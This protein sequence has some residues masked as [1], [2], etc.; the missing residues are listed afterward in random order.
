M[1]SLETHPVQTLSPAGRS[2]ILQTDGIPL[3]S[4]C[5]L[6]DYPNSPEVQ[7]SIVNHS[8]VST[9]RQPS[10]FLPVLIPVVVAFV[11][12][13][14]VGFKVASLLHPTTADIL[15][16]H[17]TP[18]PWPWLAALAQWLI[19]LWLLTGL[20]ATWAARVTLALLTLFLIIASYHWYTGAADCGCFGAVA[21]HPRWTVLLDG[22][23]LVGIGLTTA[24]SRRAF[25]SDSYPVSNLKSPRIFLAL[26]FSL[27]VPASLVFVFA[28]RSDS[29]GRQVVLL[30]TENWIGERC[31]L[32]DY[33]KDASAAQIQ[34]GHFRLLLID[35]RCA[36][37]ESYLAQLKS[38]SAISPA[39]HPNFFILDISGEFSFRSPSESTQELALRRAARY[40]ARVPLEVYL[41]NGIVA[42]V[43]QV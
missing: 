17:A 24:K 4:N 42:S 18:Q 37:C 8:A 38:L 19:A 7:D 29:E 12:L 30:D 13:T 11:L 27:S 16:T 36:R 21:V 10:S 2:A 22:A 34:K 32:L 5:P 35:R 23:M 3:L 15:R 28:S 1:L 20:T 31:P 41:V 14:A 26:V 25:A 33:L 43:R 40:F 9:V 39:W 6:S